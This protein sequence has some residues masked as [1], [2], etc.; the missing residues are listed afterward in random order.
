[1]NAY[2]IALRQAAQNLLDNIEEPPDSNCSCHINLP[3][4]DCVEYGGLREA[5]KELRELLE[6]EEFE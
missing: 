4:S 3:C 6:V 5:I 1:M 2:V